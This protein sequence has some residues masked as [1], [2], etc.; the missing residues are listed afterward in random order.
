MDSQVGIGRT[1]SA[2]IGGV[3]GLVAVLLGWWA[4]ALLQQSIASRNWL[5]VLVG[6][7]LVLSVVGLVCGLL[8]GRL[9]AFKRDMNM[10]AGVVAFIGYLV[11]FQE[12]GLVGAT[13]PLVF[14]AAF[15]LGNLR[16]E[17]VAG[18]ARKRD[19]DYPR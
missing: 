13:S 5:A 2:V 9:R 12:V 8:L 18:D 19:V 16:N 3:V 4:A 7:V 14:V 10:A 17:P 1:G 6:G 15:C 11:I